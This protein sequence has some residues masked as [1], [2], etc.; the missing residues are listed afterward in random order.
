MGWLA[1]I[2]EA[3]ARQR[4]SLQE[5]Q[6][7]LFLDE[8]ERSAKVSVFWPLLVLS[9]VIAGGG[10]IEDSTAT[11]VG[12]M[13]I[14]PLGT[15]I[16][17]AALAIA[18][19]YRRRLLGAL[20]FLALGVVVAIAI[21][22]LMGSVLPER[23]PPALNPQITGRTSP[24]I[25]DLVI[26]IATGAAGAYGLVRRDVAS[27]LPGVAIAISLVP[28]LAVVGITLGEGASDLALGALLLF[29]S[30]VVAILVAGVLVFTAAGYREQA[31]ELEPRLRS[32]A[33]W[34]VL[35]G[36]AALL[37]PL[38]VASYR[39]IEYDRWTG[40]AAQATQRWVGGSGWRYGS[41]Q[42]S[43]GTIVITI[44][45]HGPVPPV[46]DLRTAIRRTIPDDVPVQLLQ[47]DAERTGL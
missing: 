7:D 21:G 35:V 17:G 34:I 22:A 19:G 6:A 27:V 26:A 2:V 46:E 38:G 18:I 45:G 36:T 9:T 25:L 4:R 5:V 24:T 40:A 15:P 28:P 29:L 20:G 14:A 10:V 37:I 32:R 30:N 12:A 1:R 16:F 47:E 43:G 44:T 8:G 31:A 13:I 33:T 41:T 11:V 3:G 42:T 23:M 39:V